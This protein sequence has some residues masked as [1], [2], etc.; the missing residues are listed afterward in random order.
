MHLPDY[1]R[2]PL[3]RLDLAARWLA[4]IWVFVIPL[5]TAAN[6]LTRALLLLAWVMAGGFVVRWHSVRSQPL[7]WVSVAFFAWIVV[8]AT[9]TSA[10]GTAV[11]DH[12]SKYS[13]L[14]FLPLM[15]SLLQERPWRTRALNA[16]VC[17]M[18]ITLLASMLHVAWAFPGAKAT[19]DNAAG[20]HY[21]FTNYIQQNVMMSLFALVCLVRARWPASPGRRWMWLAL[22]ALAILN[23]AVFVGGRTGYLTLGACLLVFAMTSTPMRWRLPAL[24]AVAGLAVLLYAISPQAQRR[25]DQVAS[26]VQ[27]RAEDG[28]TTSSGLRMGF[29]TGSLRLIAIHPALGTGTASY[30]Q[31]F[32]RAMSPQWCGLAANGHPHNQPLHSWVENGF[33]GFLLAC[34]LIA[35]PAWLGRTA[36]APERLMLFGV[37][38][39][40][41]VHSLLNASIF[42]IEGY[43]FLTLLAATLPAVSGKARED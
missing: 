1:F 35:L 28:T 13:K 24:A 31:E 33:P 3:P 6:S 21:I 9:Y 16:F 27:S 17:A 42:H 19:Q 37:S 36:P 22:A 5:S 38:A 20:N 2:T 29:W 40:F 26:E 11:L 12:L 18:T 30:Q 43:F 7:A 34:L 4:V 15:L 14:L 25:V 39:A 10:D 32:C 41:L 8:G 23:I